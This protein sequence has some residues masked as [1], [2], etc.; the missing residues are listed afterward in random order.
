MASSDQTDN[1]LS[2][3]VDELAAV[4]IS[5]RFDGLWVLH[6][7][8]LHVRKGEVLGLIG[9][10]GA[11]K[12]TL[13]NVLTGFLRPTSGEV[14]LRGKPI[15]RLSAHKRG[16]LGVARTFQDLRLF[17]GLSVREN[18][19]AAALGS[20]MSSI[21]AKTTSRDLVTQ[22]GLEARSEHDAKHLTSGEERRLSAARAIAMRPEFLV[23]DEPS[24]GMTRTDNEHMMAIILQLKARLRF[25]IILVEHNFPMIMRLADRVHVLDYGR[26]ISVGSPTRVRADT[27]VVAAY[28]GSVADGAPA[29]LQS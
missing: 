19:E 17:S 5:V 14:L 4:D 25:G 21:G 27:R 11:G 3:E 22:F 9:P 18:V 28:L 15:S 23:L 20:G 1:G 7:V 24:A 2:S 13:I 10:N 29:K 26:T 12:T 16:R 8:N 6:K